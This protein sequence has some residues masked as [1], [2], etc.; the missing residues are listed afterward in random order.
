MALL[1]TAHGVRLGD[2]A[3]SRVYAGSD[4]VWPEQYDALIL[5]SG[6]RNYWPL[7]EDSGT[8]AWDLASGYHGTYAGPLTLA[9]GSP[10]SSRPMVDFAGGYVAVPNTGNRLQPTQQFSLGLWL[11]LTGTWEQYGTP[12]GFGGNNWDLRMDDP[13]WWRCHWWG[14]TTSYFD[15]NFLTSPT[16]GDWHYLMMVWDGLT[17]NRDTYLD[18]TLQSRSVHP[19][20]DSPANLAGLPN[21]YIGSLGGGRLFRGNVGRVAMWDRPISTTEQA[22][23]IDAV[24]I[25]SFTMPE[26]TL[27]WWSQ[28]SLSLA[29]GAAVSTWT[30]ESGNGND[31]VTVSGTPLYGANAGDGKP[32]LLWPDST[33]RHL[34][35]ASNIGISGDGH[36]TQVMVIR[37]G[38]LENQIVTGMGTGGDRQMVDLLGYGGA[39]I[40]HMHGGGNDT[41]SNAPPPLPA[42]GAFHTAVATYDG[43]LNITV[44]GTSGTPWVG[45]MSLADAPFRLGNGNYPLGNWRNGSAVRGLALF[46]RVLTLEE[47]GQVITALSS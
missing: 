6:A 22:E 1:N 8:T 13:M 11:R 42:D 2:L 44:D 30:D 12:A 15:A 18:A 24:G 32:A 39:F 33:L 43:T 19:A 28:N 41:I 20:P 21:F 35:T 16:D 29:D 31:L 40:G 46:N 7:T 23:H 38:S 5:D 34:A 4:L 27:G 25:T 3:V 37:R 45:P 14:L 17:G 10:G 47:I 36:W 9:S 26:G